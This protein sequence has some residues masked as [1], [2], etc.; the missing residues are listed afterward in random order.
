MLEK[1]GMTL[2]G[3]TLHEG[4]EQARYSVRREGCYPA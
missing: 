3:E 4:R 2:E 1:I